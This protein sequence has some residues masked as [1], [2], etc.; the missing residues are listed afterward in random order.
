MIS[1]SFRFGAFDVRD[2]KKRVGKWPT[3]DA[4]QPQ[5]VIYTRITRFTMGVSSLHAQWF[6]QNVSSLF[7]AFSILVIF[8]YAICFEREVKNHKKY[9]LVAWNY[10]HLEL[11]GFCWDLCFMR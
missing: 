6:F 3:F 10:V 8:L 9:I 4:S 11:D 5:K 7:S 1:P 2:G